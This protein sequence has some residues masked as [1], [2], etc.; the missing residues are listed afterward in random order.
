MVKA[1][2]CGFY[3]TMALKEDGTLWENG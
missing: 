2:A 3:H 1:V